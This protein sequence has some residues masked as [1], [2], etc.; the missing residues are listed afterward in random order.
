[1]K[2]RGRQAGEGADEPVTPGRQKQGDGNDGAVD[3]E[4]VA[5]GQVHDIDDRIL[6][7]IDL[8]AQTAKAPDKT[9]FQQPLPCLSG[10]QQEDQTCAPEGNDQ[11]KPFG[12]MEMISRVRAVLRRAGKSEKTGG[13]TLAVGKIILNDEKHL[14]TVAG[15]EARLTKKEYALPKILLQEPGR[16]FTREELFAAVWGY[17]YMG[18]SRTLDAHIK[19]LRKKLG[20]EKDRIETVRNVGYR[21]NPADKE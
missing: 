10:R 1:M 4:R 19:T 15:E 6:P 3:E 12:M 7:E 5:E 2:D 8:K 18:E 20:R 9:V 11:V 21:L 17:D 14:V 13:G 16:A